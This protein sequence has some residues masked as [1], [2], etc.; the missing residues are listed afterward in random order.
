MNLGVWWCQATGGG[1]GVR[2]TFLGSWVRGKLQFGLGFRRFWLRKGLFQNDAGFAGGAYRFWVGGGFGLGEFGFFGWVW[3]AASECLFFYGGFA[4]GGIGVGVEL[5]IASRGAVPS[6]ESAGWAMLGGASGGAALALFYGALAS[7]QMGLTAAVAAVVGAAIPAGIGI[8]VDG[9]PGVLA[10]AGFGLAGLGI[11]LIARPE[12]ASSEEAGLSRKGLGTA[13]VC[14][15]GFAGFYIFLQKAGSAGAF[16]LAGCSRLAALVVVSLI[17]LIGGH[18]Q[19]MDATRVG[20]SVA[21]GMLDVLGTCCFI[22]ATQ[23]GRLDEIG[24]AHV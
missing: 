2:S 17:V 1:Q 18:I 23:T 11:W 4:F 24:R 22:R 5:G 9:L 12:A 7:G 3:G 8:L 16:W 21:V 19:R 14:G 6:L 13:F 15:V 10:L 20:L